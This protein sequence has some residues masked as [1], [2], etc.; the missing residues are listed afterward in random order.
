M[1][2]IRQVTT[3]RHALS[4]SLLGMTLMG[5]SAAQTGEQQSGWTRVDLD[6]VAAHSMSTALIGKVET[7]TAVLPNAST[8]V[9]KVLS[10]PA[11]APPERISDFSLLEPTPA[12]QSSH[13]LADAPSMSVT[14]S[15]WLAKILVAPKIATEP[16]PTATLAP[17]LAAERLVSVGAAPAV[18]GLPLAYALSSTDRTIRAG[19]ERWSKDAGWNLSWEL[20]SDP[21]SGVVR[22]DADFG[23]DFDVALSKLAS[24]MRSENRVRIYL[25]AENKVLRLVEEP[26]RPVTS[27]ATPLTP[28]LEDPSLRDPSDRGLPYVTRL[29]GY[30]LGSAGTESPVGPAQALPPVLTASVALVF[31]DKSSLATVTGILTKVTRIPIALP[32]ALEHSAALLFTADQN[33]GPK[34]GPKKAAAPQARL[35][36][37]GTPKELLDRISVSTGLLWDYKDGTIVF[38]D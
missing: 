5:P 4:A 29:K 18:P 15:S 28:A 1:P 35:S 37:R 25:Y 27:A 31:S 16:E 20:P 14:G 38:T 6:S 24:A 22:F 36:Y 21:L 30:W 19:L 3:V 9:D 34:S 33:R 26:V 7:G 2:R 11:E 13:K 10:V 17:S 23:A 32:G 8:T 12:T